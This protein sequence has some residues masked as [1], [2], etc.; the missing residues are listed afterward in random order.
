MKKP[1]FYTVVGK[2]S[3][4]VMAV[5]TE[6]RSQLYGWWADDESSTHK[7]RR[8]CWGRFPD[9]ASADSVIADISRIRTRES[10]LLQGPQQE[11]VRIQMRATSEINA[12]IHAATGL[13]DV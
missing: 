9:R 13:T 11:I 2:Y 1:L 8:E 4:R 7:A 5:T 6:K 10:H 12:I 3:P